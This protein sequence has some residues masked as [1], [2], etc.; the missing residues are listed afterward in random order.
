MLE[1][2]TKKHNMRV[3][4]EICEHPDDNEAGNASLRV[5]VAVLTPSMNCVP[6]NILINARTG[7]RIS[8]QHC[9]G[10][11]VHIT[12][13]KFTPTDDLFGDKDMDLPNFVNDIVMHA[14]SD[15]S[16]DST[17]E[18]E[19]DEKCVSFDLNPPQSE[20]PKQMTIEFKE[21]AQEKEDKSEKKTGKRSKPEPKTSSAGNTPARPSILKKSVKPSSASKLLP[22]VTRGALQYQDL[23]VGSGKRVIKGHNVALQYVLRL[24]N[25]K[26]VDKA[27]R[28]RP[29]KFRL[30]IGE[31]I[32]GF[33]LGVDGMREGGE[34]HLIVPPELGYGDQDQAEI[35]PGSTLYFDV[36]VVKAF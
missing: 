33:D 25:G 27:S 29:F 20:P 19:D 1:P 23:I 16:D 18:D 9:K 28:K 32:K 34:R 5:A 2:Q 3:V 12:G 4:L 10:A 35:P 30:G 13:D 21:A 24:E 6:V 8:G 15:E 22:M 36:T 26:L 7:I 14:D 17:D 11:V 31:C